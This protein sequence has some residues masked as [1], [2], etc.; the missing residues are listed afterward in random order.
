MK[1]YDEEYYKSI[2]Q[3][4]CEQADCLAVILMEMYHP[5]S[6]IDLG[7]ATGLYLRHFHENGIQVLS[8]DISESAKKENVIPKD[9]IHIRD[10][11]AVLE[12]KQKWDVCLC[13]ETLEHI[14]KECEEQVIKNLCNQSDVIIF[15][16]AHPSQGG[17]N[18]INEQPKSHWIEQFKKL[19]YRVNDDATR[20][21]LLHLKN[22]CV[23]IRSWLVSNLVVFENGFR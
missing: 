14:K 15:S 8:V 4:E 21:L 23:A 9:L 12:S 16:A 13:I 6:V 2:N 10:L 1:E 18:H 20:K 11:C 7:G 17:R 19:N 5:S 3:S 22:D